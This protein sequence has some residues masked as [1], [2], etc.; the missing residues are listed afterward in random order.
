MRPGKGDMV[1]FQRGNIWH[2]VEHEKGK[3][4]LITLAAFLVYRTRIKKFIIG[5]D[6]LR[7]VCCWNKLLW[8]AKVMQF[9]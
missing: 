7:F 6:A 9:K 5:V 2:R 4:P 1:L 3:L 8:V